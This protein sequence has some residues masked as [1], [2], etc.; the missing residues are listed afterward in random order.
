MKETLIELLKNKKVLT[1]EDIEFAYK[2]GYYDGR[3]DL[4]VEQMDKAINN[5]NKRK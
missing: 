4:L 3:T 1:I 5:E 2:M